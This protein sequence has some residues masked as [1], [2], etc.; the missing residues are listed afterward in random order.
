MLQKSLEKYKREKQTAFQN[1]SRSSARRKRRK[2]MILEDALQRLRDGEE[3]DVEKLPLHHIEA[4][5]TSD[6]CAG[7]LEDLVS[8][9]KLF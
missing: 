6:D 1:G 8:C 7:V 4:P 9:D 2:I 5:V 3:I